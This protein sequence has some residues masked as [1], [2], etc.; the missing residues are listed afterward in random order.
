MARTPKRPTFILLGTVREF[1][2]TEMTDRENPT[3]PPE[4]AGRCTV[5]P[6]GAL[7]FAEVFIAPG[8]L[9]TL[10]KRPAEDDRL[11]WIVTAAINGPKTGITISFVRPATASDL[12]RLNAAI[13][14][15][16]DLQGAS[17]LVG[18]SLGGTPVPGDEA[19]ST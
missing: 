8:V 2:L 10:P 4:T 16:Q 1:E 15:E 7:A 9:T 11:A 6:D 18:A 3:K 5:L 13:P 12:T 17:A 14:D 19:P